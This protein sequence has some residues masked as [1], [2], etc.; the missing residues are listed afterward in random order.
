MFFEI[1]QKTDPTASWPKTNHG[2]AAKLQD[3][4]LITVPIP[5]EVVNTLVVGVS[6]NGKTTFTKK[7]IDAKL[8]E[9]P[10]LFCV[11]FQVKP[12]DFT[13]EFLRLRPNDKVITYSDKLF[14]KNTFRWNLVKEVRVHAK[15]EWP[16]VLEEI[17]SI[18]FADLLEDKRNL[19]WADAGKAAF[20]GFILVLLHCY[21]N[22]PAN[23][24]VIS[25]MKNMPR[26]EFLSF[27]AKY[28]PNHS[29]L[30]DSFGYDPAQANDYQ[31]TRRASDIF[32]FLNNVLERFGGTFATIDGEDTIYEYL[33]G[34]YTER[35]FIV[36]DH[37]TKDSAKYFEQYIFKYIGNEMLSQSSD[38]QGRQML[39][40]LDEIDK[41]EADINL[42]QIITLGRQFGL[43]VLVSTQS[44]ESLFAIAPE[45]Q[46]DHLTKA[47]LAGFGMT[48]ACH[49]GDALTIQT[50]QGLYGKRIKQILTL[51]LSRY[52]TPKIDT[53]WQP[54]VDDQ[55]F[56][57]LGIGECY[58]KLYASDPVRCKILP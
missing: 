42:S 22:N 1:P 49:P 10:N 28:T 11:F 58:I 46:G 16:T 43:Q 23:G 26:K 30:K 51:P 21:K 15:D 57:N 44:L 33:Q 54:I 47:A 9:N 3:G 12:D 37:K 35:L 55:D 31:L 36:H 38:F 56:A 17:A 18:L 25:A 2:I 4:S 45:I 40:V 20:K 13:E 27:L 8:K 50:L 5:A 7:F 48:V 39:W 32:F 41:I 24:K 53:Q 6:G 19:I 14:P 52:D 34:R 29:F